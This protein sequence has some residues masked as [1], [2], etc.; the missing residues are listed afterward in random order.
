[1]DKIG[2]PASLHRALRQSPIPAQATFGC[3][4]GLRRFNGKPDLARS[5]ARTTVNLAVDDQRSPDAGTD[6][7]HQHRAALAASAEQML[8]DREGI[9]IVV[10]PHW[11]VDA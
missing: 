4:A 3:D 1:M 11:H 5:E 9:G 8:G 10:D 2:R 7:Q 6:D